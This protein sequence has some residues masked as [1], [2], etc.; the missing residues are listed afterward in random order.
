MHWPMGFH[1]HGIAL[2]LTAT[3]TIWLLLNQRSLAPFILGPVLASFLAGVFHL[4]PFGGYGG[5]T[6]LFLVPFLLLLLSLPMGWAAGKAGGSRWI[7]VLVSCLLVVLLMHPLR[8]VASQ[9]R[10]GIQREEL[11]PVLQEVQSLVEPG[12][13]VYV[14]HGAR[15]PLLYYDRHLELTSVRIVNGSSPS[16]GEALPRDLDSLRSFGRVWVVASWGCAGS[17]EE[18]EAMAAYLRQSARMMTD[19]RRP[20]ARAILFDFGP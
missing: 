5:R 18:V 16:R 15:F 2:F 11:W 4:Y 3:G 14:Y 13:T 17:E 1:S 12:E 9:F 20:G 19:I 6:I 7:P 10:D 8:G